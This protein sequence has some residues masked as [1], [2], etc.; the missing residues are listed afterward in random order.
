MPHW[1]NMK[2]TFVNKKY[3]QWLTVY[4]MRK[5]GFP[6]G[7]FLRAICCRLSFLNIARRRSKLTE[8]KDGYAVEQMSWKQGVNIDTYLLK[9]DCDHNFDN[10]DVFAECYNSKKMTWE[11]HLKTLWVRW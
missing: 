4:F 3:R 5:M 10:I 8:I 6:K 7:I 1:V 11:N 2:F 9:K